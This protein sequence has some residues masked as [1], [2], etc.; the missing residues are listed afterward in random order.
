MTVTETLNKTAG[1]F[2]TLIVNRKKSG[3]TKYCAQILGT[4]DKTV[5]FYD[6]NSENLRRVMSQNIVFVRSG[7]LSY[8]RK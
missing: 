3:N 5:S 4:T 8:R 6:V 1:R 7:N 2:T